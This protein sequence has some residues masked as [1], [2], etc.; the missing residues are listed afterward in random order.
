MKKPFIKS[1]ILMLAVT[2][3]LSFFTIPAIAAEAVTAPDLGTSSTFGLMANTM[4]TVATSVSGDVGSIT[5]TVVPAITNGGNHINDSEYTTASIALTAAIDSAKSKPVDITG[6]AGADLGGLTLAPGVYDY[7]GAVNIGSDTTLSGDGVYIFRI[8]GTLDTAANTNIA[9]IDGAQ[10]CNVFWVVDGATTLAANTNFKGN[11]LSPSSATTVGIN[12]SIDGRILSQNAVTFTSPGPVVITV[13]TCSAPVTPIPAVPSLPTSQQ[14]VVTSLCSQEPSTSRNWQVHNPN[15]EQVAF[16][17]NIEGT[18]QVG[19]STINGNSDLVI[20][21]NT[22]GSNKLNILVNSITQASLVSLGETCESVPIIPAVPIV[23]NTPDAAIACPT[24]EPQDGKLI[25]QTTSQSV[26]LMSNG[27]LF[28]NAVL[29]NELEARGTWSF[30]LGGKEYSI[31]GNECISYTITDAPVGKYPAVT[32]FNPEVGTGI[33]IETVTLTVPTVTGG[34]LPK[35]A[36]PWY[37]L[38]L[39]GF[40]FIVISAAITWRRMRQYE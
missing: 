26:W 39:L 1:S 24:T 30:T 28:I 34:Q 19:N 9:L 16:E 11:L 21:T 27:S 38:L 23:D 20:R 14:L 29:P 5:Q 4:T 15:M 8:A 40:T 6:S 12:V 22:E 25:S 37:N 31:V 32:K 17:Y 35:T 36:S 18:T 13:P 3:I 10:A 33:L 7:P 2:L